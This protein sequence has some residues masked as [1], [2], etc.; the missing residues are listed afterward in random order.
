M[1][2]KDRIYED[3]KN[4]YEIIERIGKGGFGKVYKVKEK[5]TNEFKAIKIIDNDEQN[6]KGI[7][8]IINNELKNMRLC[9]NDNKNIYSVKL[10]EYFI[11][12]KEFVIVMELCDDN[13]LKI[14]RKKNKEGFKPD[15]I[16]NIMSQLNETF[17]IM[18]KNK[19][20]HRDI[21][22]ENI[23]VKYDNEDKEK[24]IVKLTD[25]GISKQVSATTMFK[26]GVGTSAT[27]APEILEG[28]EYSNKCDLW[29]I[30]VIIYQLA[31]NELPFE[32]TTQ[33]VL[34][35][36]IL[37]KKPEDFKKTKNENLNKLIRH[38]LV[39]DE[40]KRLSWESYFY[41]P[42]FK[43]YNFKDDYN[44][45]YSLGDK[46]GKGSFGDV[47]KATNKM[48]GEIVA[49]KKID[50]NDNEDEED[51]DNGIKLIIDELK[52][53]DICANENSV[54][55]YDYFR[56]KDEFIITMELCD[57]NLEKILFKKKS[58]NPDEI[59]KIMSQLNNTFKIMVRNKIVHRDL[60][61]ENILV[62][63]INKDDFIVKL[64]DYGISK[65]VTTTNIC[66]TFKGTYAT[67]APEILEGEGEKE[68]DNKCDL[69]S[70]GII[71]YKL[72]FNDYPYK[73][74]TQFAILK[75]INS[76]LTTLKLTNN[77]DLDNLIRGLLIKDVRERMTWE[78]YFKHPFFKKEKV[79]TT[80]NEP[81]IQ[82]SITIN[83]KVS[84]ADKKKY[85]KIF[86]L[87]NESL[88][89]N[90]EILIIE[91]NF[92]ELNQENTELY[93]DGEKK[94]FK[95]YFEPDLDEK[96]NYEIK[97]IIKT[98]L[99]SCNSMF[100]GCL[101]I[102]KIDLSL[103]DSSKVKDMSSMFR[104]CFSL[105]ELILG[106][107]NTSKVTNMKQMFQKCKS[108]KKI[109]FPSSFTTEKVTDI[110][111][112][113]MDC[114]SL[115]EVN[116]NYFKTKNV[117]NMKGLFKNCFLLKK[118]D[119]SSFETENVEKMTLMFEGCTNLEEI[120]LEPKKFKTTSLECMGHMFTNCISLKAVNLS[121]FNTE[122]VKYMCY[123]FSN[124][125]QLSDMDLS[126]FTTNELTD[127]SNM[128]NGCQNLT[129]INLT[130]FGDKDYKFNNMFDGCSN[131][132]EVKVNEKI[133]NKFEEVFK[134]INFKI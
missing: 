76:K 19:I 87:E 34:L 30:G 44:K 96:E 79:K 107:L 117:V 83:I 45:Y 75:N 86:F 67:M 38:L 101:H 102:R 15:E 116:L 3:Y 66:K 63:Y 43:N 85:K 119:L 73:G 69:W 106:N 4:Y 62:K 124:C 50:I 104:K 98:K 37:E 60:K 6:E 99:N 23:L 72:F 17:R 11:N 128:F 122:K 133:K 59:C 84:I 68:Y 53:M 57:T 92:K 120:T 71:M 93:I 49:L 105:E 48:T 123:M 13:L 7:N 42:F 5:S 52:S 21:K 14:L 54:R 56:N 35:K 97:L 25:Y 10:Y 70:I 28:K 20:V 130:S 58:F 39:Y 82:Q 26:T 126:N 27:M 94:E 64:S 100:H 121:S 91:E 2:E 112:M 111:L 12:E 131:L 108:L 29:S 51:I 55:L 40:E 9:S 78:E 41:H 103:F 22:L 1:E 129:K 47:F 16:Y 127:N 109:N 118:L 32:G 134:N 46:I 81:T 36:N 113:F 61:L 132:K 65:Q 114:N 24:F 110:S 74:N 31:F 95:K 33:V 88:K 80:E 8:L 89:R 90:E 18:V 77:T 125:E 115:E